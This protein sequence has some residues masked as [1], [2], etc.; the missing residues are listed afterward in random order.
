MSGQQST[1]KVKILPV[2]EW[3]AVGLTARENGLSVGE[4]IIRLALAHIPVSPSQMRAIYAA[5]RI[6]ANE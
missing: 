3:F 6:G 1:S 5:Y 4:I 2:N